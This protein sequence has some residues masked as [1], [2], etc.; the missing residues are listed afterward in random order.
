MSGWMAGLSSSRTAST[1]TGTKLT[2]PRTRAPTSS[3][4]EWCRSSSASS[5]TSTSSGG[6][7]SSLPSC[8]S[9]TPPSP[10][11]SPLARPSQV[12]YTPAIVHIHAWKNISV[13]KCLSETG[14]HSFFVCSIYQA[15][16]GRRRCMARRSEWMSL[17]QRRRHG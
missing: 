6:S 14:Y 17:T 10:S 5:P 4:S 7:P 11:A 3:P 2:A 12:P 8:P 13:H 9:P 15:L 16:R 1:G